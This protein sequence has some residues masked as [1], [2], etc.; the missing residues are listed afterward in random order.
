MDKNKLNE[1]TIKEEWESF[2]KICVPEGSSQNQINA[3]E[4]IFYSGAYVNMLI[5]RFIAACEI[6]EQEAKEALNRIESEL[7]DFM[8]KQVIMA[9]LKTIIEEGKEVNGSKQD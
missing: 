3:S 6:P 4:R 2:K 1:L 7:S 9:A 5:M 8:H